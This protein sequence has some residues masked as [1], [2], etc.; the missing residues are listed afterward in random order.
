ML[1]NRTTAGPRPAAVAGSFYPASAEHLGRTVSALLAAAR[2]REQPG[3]RGII[4]PHAA[5]VYSGPTAAEAF[6]SMRHLKGSI[7]RVIVVG[8]AHYVPFRGVAAP[9]STAFATPL[10]ESPVETSAV[11]AMAEAGLVV[12]DDEPHAPEHALEVELPFL[13]AIFGPL[14]IVP[15]LFGLTSARAVAAVLARVWT[16]KTFLVVSSD[17]S[18]YEEYE[19]ACRHDASTARSIETLDEGAI[20]P[21]DACGHLAIRGALIEAKRRCA[22]VLRLDLRNSGDTAGDKRSVVGYGAWAFTT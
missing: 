2:S 21:A 14:P 6:A 5:Y 16:C 20:G 7:D 9:S 3:L 15:L 11:A 19:D 18:H 4:A 1:L 22:S 13:Q 8:P 17:L 10:G 12:I